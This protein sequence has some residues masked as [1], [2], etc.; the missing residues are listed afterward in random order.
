M[1]IPGPEPEPEPVPEPEPEPVPEPEPEPVPEPE[2]EFI[3]EPEPEFIPEPE[4]ELIP[5]PEPEF[6][7]EPEPEPIPEPE[8]EPV[9]EP[10]PIPEPEPTWNPERFFQPEPAPAPAPEPEPVPEP[11]PM[12][13]PEPTWNP[14]R[15]FQPE[16]APAPAPEPEP[17]PEPEPMPAPEPAWNPEQFFEPAQRPAPQ[18]E[19]EPI[20]A[21]IPEP[22]PAPIPDPIP[23]PAPQPT[24]APQPGLARYSDTFVLNRYVSIEQIQNSER[25][26]IRDPRLPEPYYTRLNPSMQ[27]GFFL[28]LEPDAKAA[29]AGVQT[30]GLRLHVIPETGL[31]T[32]IKREEP[33]VLDYTVT[34]RQVQ[35]G[36]RIQFIHERL[37]R[38]ISL[39]LNP[40]TENG[41]LLVISPGRGKSSFEEFYLRLLV[42]P[43]EEPEEPEDGTVRVP[44]PLRQPAPA[45]QPAY[46]P[47]QPAYN[48]PAP[49]PAYAPPA[50]QP[51]PAPVPSGTLLASGGCN[52]RLTTPDK[53]SSFRM[54]GD[55]FGNM[56]VYSDRIELFKKSAGVAVAFGM[57]GSAIEGKGKSFFTLWPAQVVR[58]EKVLN[59]KGALAWYV[60]SLNDGRALRLV[61]DKKN[62]SEPFIN[63][64]F[65]C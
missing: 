55:D 19:P 21:P 41:A 17:V 25:I 58:V 9:P 53:L 5:E 28:I 62:K 63:R 1:F 57:I 48:P 42:V 44:L 14:E 64:L 6:I 45:P 39:T 18:P 54:G 22:A 7:P 56:D 29:A 36:E 60:F 49:Q 59:K 52:F 15:F 8:P 23:Q 3:P 34:K 4:P 10:E 33:L 37:P 12:P 46:N 31:T 40:A 61:L 27:D 2:P 16:P 30:F 11:E 50:P 20:P 13:E 38:K 43:D 35:A 32:P 24:P 51:A 65:N 47:P 26:E